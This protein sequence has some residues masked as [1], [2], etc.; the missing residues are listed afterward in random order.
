MEA[1][2]GINHT[3]RETRAA[4]LSAL[5]DATAARLARALAHGTT[6]LECKTGYGLDLTTEINLLNAIALD[7]DQGL[8]RMM[9]VIAAKL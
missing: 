3:V 4:D 5:V 9:A 8:D 2:G 6:K 7:V 1:G